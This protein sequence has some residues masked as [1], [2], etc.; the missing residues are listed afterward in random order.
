MV[1]APLF[2]T[3]LLLPAIQQKNR[4]PPNINRETNFP[5]TKY[6][7]PIPPNRVP[8]ISAESFLCV[9]PVRSSRF[10]GWVISA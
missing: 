6:L 5:L 10:I 8:F 3:S 1:S 7:L 2:A 4:M 9:K